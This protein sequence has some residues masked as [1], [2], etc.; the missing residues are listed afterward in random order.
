MAVKTFVTGTVLTAADTNTYLANSGLVFVKQQSVGAVAVSNVVVTSAF[1]STYDNYRVIFTGCTPSLIDSWR[2]M[3]GTGAT[4]QHFGT[5]TYRDYNGATNGFINANNA[6]SIYLTLNENGVNNTFVSID[7][8]S[9]NLATNTGLMG[10]SF[11]RTQ[12][13]TCIGNVFN[14]TQ[15]T[16]FTILPDSAGTMTNGTITVYGYRKE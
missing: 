4:T 9:P 3:M 1:S 14:N 15:Y 11:G 12:S 8:I 13:Q 7:I 2:L 6:G 10:S 5:L 16:S